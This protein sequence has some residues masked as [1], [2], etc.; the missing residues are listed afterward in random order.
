MAKRL[1]AALGVAAILLGAPAS[2]GR[3]RIAVIV[4][5]ERKDALDISTVAR[6]YLRQ[7][8]FWEDGTPVIPLN[9]EAGSSLREE[10]SQRVFGASSD[11]MSGYW[12]ERY[13]HGVLPPATLSSSAAMKRYI[14]AER[15]AIGYVEA[16]AADDSVRVALILD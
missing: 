16:E 3:V 7:R 8:R 2:A 15:N 13:F 9:R 5:R 6:L 1:L 4:H 10:F 12:N 11:Q 14:A